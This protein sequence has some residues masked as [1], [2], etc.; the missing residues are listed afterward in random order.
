[1]S[2]QEVLARNSGLSVKTVNLILNNKQTIT[3]KTAELLGKTF[4]TS[5]EMWLS[6]SDKHEMREAYYK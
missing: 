6:L 1:M 2:Y 4:S 5:A 3:L